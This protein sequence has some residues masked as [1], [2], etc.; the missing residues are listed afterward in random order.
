M[1]YAYFQDTKLQ[2]LIF[3]NSQHQV[4]CLTYGLVNCLLV[5]ALGCVVYN[6]K[7]TASSQCTTHMYVLCCI[8]IESRTI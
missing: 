1:D 3:T 6:Y 2:G 4:V 7:I 5:K 8:E